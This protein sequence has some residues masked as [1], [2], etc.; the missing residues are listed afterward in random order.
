MSKL[1]DALSDFLNSGGYDLGYSH[2]DHPD[3]GSFDHVL[4]SRINVWEYHGK[5]EKEYYS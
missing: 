4:R 1:G 2:Y 3:L 5:T